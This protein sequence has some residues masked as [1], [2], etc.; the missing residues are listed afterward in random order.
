MNLVD[1]ALIAVVIAAAVSGWRGGL[2]SGVTGVL[3]FLGGAVLGVRLAPLVVDRF[4]SPLTRSTASVGIVIA[5]AVLGQTLAGALGSKLRA[6]MPW[7]PLRAGDSL[8]GSVV[9][10]AATLVVAW[11]LAVALVS[12]PPTRLSQQVRTSEL[13]PRID[14]VMPETGRTL[15]TS[16]RSAFGETF[17]P[18]VYSGITTPEI[19]AVST[20]DAAVTQTAKARAVGD[21]VVEVLS[22][23]PGCNR[24]LTGSGFVFA[25][26]RVMTNAH[27]VAGARSVVVRLRGVGQSYAAR[28]VLFDPRRDVAVLRVDD[29][30]APALRFST[31]RAK[32]G[33]SA[34]VAGFPGGGG[35]T[36]QAARIRDVQRARGR[37]IY[38]TSSVVREVYSLRATIRQ[39]GSGGP[40][41][42]ETGQVLGV[43]FA[44]STVDPLT[45]YA[46]TA[47]EVGSDAQAGARASAAVSTG[48]C[49]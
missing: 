25:A 40:L 39:G 33:D 45:G 20:P 26:Q 36:L 42:D 30:S 14:S 2:V 43:V 49:D 48:G 41:T 13:L 19:V 10:V 3:G 38:D 37:D 24:S 23:A 27:V 16:L 29:L 22:D 32:R 9:S 21:S 11:G 4:D 44:S 18:Q 5:L 31:D 28:V 46:L 1:V 8:G 15:F 17:F 47:Q 34:L 7:K 35:Y 12:G 6:S